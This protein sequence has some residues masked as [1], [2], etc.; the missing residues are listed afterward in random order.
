MSSVSKTR[1]MHL[2]LIVCVL[3]CVVHQHK[4]TFFSECKKDIVKCA[5][6]LYS[7]E[8]EDRRS[9]SVTRNIGCNR[10]F[11]NN[12]EPSLTGTTSNKRSICHIIQ[13]G[14]LLFGFAAQ[15]DVIRKIPD[16][17]AF[18]I[19]RIN[20]NARRSTYFKQDESLEPK[21][22]QAS[23]ADYTGSGFNK[24]H[25][26]AFSFQP[27]AKE[28]SVTNLYTNA[29]PQY[30]SFNK[31]IWYP[32]G[33]QRLKKYAKD[34]CLANGG[35]M[36]VVVGTQGEIGHI[37]KGNVTVPRYFWTAACCDLKGRVEA[38]AYYGEN[39]ESGSSV[40]HRS[41]SQL[42]TFLN[43]GNYKINIFRGNRNCIDVS[44]HVSID[45]ASKR[46]PNEPLISR[47]PQKRK[48]K[49]NSAAAEAAHS[50]PVV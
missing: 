44:N 4:A 28:A 26:I 14:Q 8:D 16:W 48:R 35:E 42:Q 18:R 2:I 24:G 34:K 46:L 5:L 23:N 50:T 9:S 7:L 41:V 6:E 19:T 21:D 47:S 43:R 13:E 22:S 33:E 40:R 37:G 36:Y 45:Y 12:V 30:P 25:L 27:P 32:K 17:S 15:H 39:K 1:V 31:H 3:I 11:I 10:F 38:F 29:A 49:F 20:T